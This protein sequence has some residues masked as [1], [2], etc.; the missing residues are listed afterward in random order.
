M[1]RDRYWPI[2]NRVLLDGKRL[3]LSSKSTFYGAS[4][5][6]IPDRATTKNI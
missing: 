5:F 1:E 2:S 6:K 3:F 4:C